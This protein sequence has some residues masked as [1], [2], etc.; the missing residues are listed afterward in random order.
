MI[1]NAKLNELND[2]LGQELGRNK[3]MEPKF[4]W[5]FSESYLHDMVLAGKRDFGEMVVKDD[6]GNDS[7]K[8]LVTLK[9]V[10]Q[11]RKMCLFLD[12]QW[13][14]SCWKWSPEPIWRSHFG[15]D[16]EWPSRGLYFPV[17]GTALKPG[18]EPDRGITW[19]FINTMSKQLQRKMAD[20]NEEA[21][22]ALD[23]EEKAAGDLVYDK[24]DDLTNAFGSA[25]PGSRNGGIST[26]SP[27]YTRGYDKLT[28]IE[29]KHN[30]SSEQ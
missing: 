13:L 5:V 14:L 22:R 24:I 25:K 1:S 8:R 7:G 4:K 23:R 20:M 15:S 18:L 26:P 27:E 10:T 6:A 11:R 3:F 30:V 16:L 2:L 19:A 28:E 12:N 9:R 17:D 29:H 21:I